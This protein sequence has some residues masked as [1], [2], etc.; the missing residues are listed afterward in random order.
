MQ[1]KNP[2]VLNHKFQSYNS[3]YIKHI[4]ILYQNCSNYAPGVKPGPSLWGH[5]FTLNYKGKPSI[6]VLLNRLSQLKLLM[7]FIIK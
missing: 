5:N 2:T 1:L 4:E 7:R 6:D 3:W